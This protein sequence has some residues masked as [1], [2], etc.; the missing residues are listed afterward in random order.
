ME[1]GHETSPKRTSFISYQSK[2]NTTNQEVLANRT[3][4]K[5]PLIPLGVGFKL[6]GTGLAL[7]S[8]PLEVI[9]LDYNNIKRCLEILTPLACPRNMF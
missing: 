5:K 1:W 3:G 7:R 6:F 2:R 9:C 4:N 8:L